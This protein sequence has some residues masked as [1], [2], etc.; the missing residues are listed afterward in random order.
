MVVH[1]NGEHTY[2]LPRPNGEVV[3]GGTVQPGNWSTESSDDDVRAIWA[4]CC[5]LCPAVRDSEVLATAAGLRPGRTNSTRVELDPRCLAN[6]AIV[7]HNYGHAG[8]GHTLQWGCAQDVV[9]A[10]HE[11]W[12]LPGLGAASR[13]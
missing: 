13:L 2:I 6:G 1:A 8:S 10:A 7:I 11:H 12:P 4:R 3:L 9:A 5:A